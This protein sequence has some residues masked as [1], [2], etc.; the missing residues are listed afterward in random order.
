LRVKKFYV[1]IAIMI[2][3]VCTTI[4]Y[5]ITYGVKGIK[6]T[7][8]TKGQQVTEAAL[9]QAIQVGSWRLRV[10]SI[11]EATYIRALGCGIGEFHKAPEGTKIVIITLKIENG[12]VEPVE[13]IELESVFKEL[14]LPLLVTNLNKS[15]E[16]AYTYQLDYIWNWWE[17]PREVRENAVM[18]RELELQLLLLNRE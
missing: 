16:R 14:S 15:Y 3:I 6:V 18:Y 1:I 9:G 5:N 12:G 17:L 10:L 4:I 8:G 11:R 13:P 7:V 2:L